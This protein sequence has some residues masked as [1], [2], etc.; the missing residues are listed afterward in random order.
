M[1]GMKCI[2]GYLTSSLSKFWRHCTGPK[3]M[4]RRSTTEKKVGVSQAEDEAVIVG[5]FLFFRFV[6]P[7]ITQTYI[8]FY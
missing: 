5:Y 3:L 1:V 6:G 8:I 2:L 7:G 4:L